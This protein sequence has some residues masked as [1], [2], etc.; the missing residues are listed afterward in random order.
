M[1]HI[2]CSLRS[3]LF[4]STLALSSLLALGA[5]TARADTAAPASSATSQ[6]SG[7]LIATF[8]KATDT[9]K[10]PY[11]LTLKNNG[12]HSLKVTV[13]IQSSAA[14]HN[15]AKD[16]TKKHHIKAG[17]SWTIPNLAAGDKVNVTADGITPLALT[18]Q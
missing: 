15:D 5:A 1:K 12:D 16:K 6:S 18:V 7:P 14:A 2:T 3:A 9:D 8:D 4:G 17:Q 13:E 11:I 10:G